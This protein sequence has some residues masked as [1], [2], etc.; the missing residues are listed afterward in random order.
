MFGQ[1]ITSANYSV[2]SLQ[3]GVLSQGFHTVLNLQISFTFCLGLFQGVRGGR[4][5]LPLQGSAALAQ[6]PGP[7]SGLLGV[8][9]QLKM[10]FAFLNGQDP[11][12]G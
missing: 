8:A 10:V 7:A 12:Q 2:S 9:C 11:G 1:C 3:V 4:L 5:D 6:E